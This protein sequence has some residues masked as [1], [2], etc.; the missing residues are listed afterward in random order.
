M[1]RIQTYMVGAGEKA[2]DEEAWD[3]SIFPG[4]RPGDVHRPWQLTTIDNFD[5]LS[6]I[7]MSE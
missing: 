5:E 4:T 2:W 7:K 3:A 1:I 6:T